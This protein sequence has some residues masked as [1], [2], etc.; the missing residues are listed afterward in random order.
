MAAY[1]RAANG[2]RIVLYVN[3]GGTAASL[4]SSDA[5]LRL[6]S[7]FL[8]ALPFDRSEGRGVMARFAEQGVPVLTLLNIRDLAIRWGIPLG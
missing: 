7:G 4:G 1:R 8:P 3:V 2:R 5:V 6:R